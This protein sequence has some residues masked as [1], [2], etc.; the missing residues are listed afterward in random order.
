MN[1]LERA[2]YLLGIMLDMNPEFRGLTLSEI[3]MACDEKIMNITLQ[4]TFEIAKL[5]GEGYSEEEII[6]LISNITFDAEDNI[7]EEEANYIKKDANKTL[8]LM[9]RNREKEN[10]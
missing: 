7:N 2:S 1:N 3:C 5:I 4:L 6:G 10:D 9:L 8:K